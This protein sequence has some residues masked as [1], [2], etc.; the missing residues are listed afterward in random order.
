MSRAGLL[1][2]LRKETR[3]SIKKNSALQDYDDYL[4]SP[5]E[6]L[7]ALVKGAAILMLIAYVFYRSI[8]AFIIALPGLALYLIRERRNTVRRRRHEL[9]LQFR[10]MMHAVIAGLQA[11]YSI[12]NSFVH[13]YEDMKLLYGADAMISRELKSIA[14][15]LKNNQN[16]EDVLDDLAKRAH[17]QDI[18]DFAEVFRIAKRSGGDLPGILRNTADLI[19]DRIEV[20]REI[21]T[22]ISSKKMEQ[23]IM[24][25]VPFGIIL[26]IDATSPGFFDPL[27][28][29]PFGVAVMSGMLAVY[30]GA[31]LLAEKIL[32]IKY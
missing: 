22:Q 30:I 19:G 25:L 4:L 14:R 12:E 21:A 16:I 20:Q 10:E 32:D 24:D 29:S 9:M 17:I 26:Y 5:G 6:W 11:G 31:Y 28:H 13:A 18:T 7:F 2:A 23:G 15:K 3:W 27:Y 1:G 8:A